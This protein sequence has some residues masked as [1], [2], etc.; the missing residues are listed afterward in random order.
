LYILVTPLLLAVHSERI[1]T[2][3]RPN[4]DPVVFQALTREWDEKVTPEEY[5]GARAAARK[6]ARVG[7]EDRNRKIRN[8]RRKILLDAK[9]AAQGHK[10]IDE[11]TARLAAQAAQQLEFAAALSIPKSAEELFAEAAGVKR[12]FARAEALPEGRV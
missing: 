2:A 9:Q 5:R 4:Q 3:P 11:E 10:E 6:I 12:S 1:P 8:I 7:L